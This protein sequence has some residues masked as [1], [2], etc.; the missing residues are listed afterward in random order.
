MDLQAMDRAHRIG[1][2]KQVRVYR[3]IT[4]NTME[5]KQIEKQTMKLKLDT[6]II[7]KGRQSSNKTA[8]QKDDLKDMVNYGADAIF[9][10]GSD[11]ED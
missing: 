2:K 1:Q 11:M 10:I 6:M 3:L 9:D 7:Q 8:M 5:V 4:K